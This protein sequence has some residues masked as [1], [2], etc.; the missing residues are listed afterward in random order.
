MSKFLILLNAEANFQ[1]EIN[2]ETVGKYRIR[3]LN[4]LTGFLDKARHWKRIWRK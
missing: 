2:N 3:K 1:D 4:K